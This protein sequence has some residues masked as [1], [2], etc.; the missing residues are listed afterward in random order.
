MMASTGKA[1]A[2]EALVAAEARFTANNPLS[3]KQHELAVGTSPGGNTRTLLWTSPFPLSMK[4]G[5][6]AYVW[7][8][9]G[10]KYVDFV[11]EL[12]AGLYGHSH[13]TVREAILSTFDNVG[14]SLGATTA[15]EQRYA[16][17]LCDRFRLDRVRMTNSG[18]E[19]N[20][21][22][23]AGARHFTGR[24]KV[25]VFSGGYHGAVLSFPSSSSGGEE[26][27]GSP[28]H[29][30]AAPN[31]VDRADFVV[32]PRY[33]DVASARAIIAATPDLA[34]VLVEP[35]QGAGGC[36]PGTA[37]FLRAVQ[38]AAHA[39]GAL[40][41]LDEVMT[42]R[43][44][45][46]GLGAD[47]LLDLLRPDL[48][49]LG[50]Y[51]GGGL[52]FGAFGGRADVMAVYDPR[53][54]GALAHSGTFNNNTLAMCVGYAALS[55][56]YTSEVNIEFNK[57]GDTF[58]ERLK[59]VARGT[60]LSLTGR[61]SL[62]GLHFTEDG[63]EEISCG[64]DIKGK[65]RRDLR[66]LFWFEMLEAGFWTTRRGFIALILE[67]PDEALDA[68][69]EAVRAFLERHRDI[70]LQQQQQRRQNQQPP[71]Q[72]QQPQRQREPQHPH[73]RQQNQTR[74][75]ARDQTLQEY[76]RT[77]WR[78]NSDGA[79]RQQRQDYDGWAQQHHCLQ[80]Q[81]ARQWQQATT[82]HLQEDQEVVELV[83]Q[84]AELVRA[85]QEALRRAQRE[86]D[87]ARAAFQE[88]RQIQ[89]C[90]QHISSISS[91]TS[92][93]SNTSNT[94]C[95][96]PTLLALLHRTNA[97]A[98]GLERL[99]S[100]VTTYEDRFAR[101][102][103]RATRRDEVHAFFRPLAL[104]VRRAAAEIIR[105]KYGQRLQAGGEREAWFC[106][107]WEGICAWYCVVEGVE[108]QFVDAVGRREIADA[109]RRYLGALREF[110][111]RMR[112][113]LGRVVL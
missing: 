13:P 89:R 80:D 25:V 100:L 90:D 95:P 105:E 5:K 108:R 3:K 88:A 99:H 75:L 55:R 96:Q 69:V 64:E 66:D 62:I 11:G 23:L 50:K 77:L 17:L 14:L 33:N 65:E 18:T 81:A 111:E 28:R 30:A 63:T 103:L 67:T 92:T 34:A 53:V 73:P 6:G 47:E 31:T 43:L 83:A 38:E 24:R 113:G 106:A 102:E 48:V 101:A 76:L 70:M 94:T 57:R 29:A 2:H 15:Y 49:T 8:E 58:R 51:L 7:D 9:D 110:G 84:Q 46:R 39:R 78:G 74:P 21:H 27:A 26:E 87:L 45:P 41:V 52:A 22:A 40:F 86:A 35:L 59:E 1:A 91:T 112:V 54:D 4:Q 10:H 16:S 85:R 68:F 72:Q 20:L 44:A 109:W 97:L 71:R 36:I 12:S 79:T 60:R 19:A 82:R 37:A 61:G 93:T 42:S 32:A 98:A 104:A 107:E 56:V